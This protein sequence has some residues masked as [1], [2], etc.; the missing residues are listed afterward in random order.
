[1]RGRCGE[2]FCVRMT[3]HQGI[4]FLGLSRVWVDAVRSSYGV[5]RREEYQMTKLFVSYCTLLNEKHEVCDLGIDLNEI[6]GES[7]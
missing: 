6:R 1:M 2:S 7:S 5:Y 4:G 3:D